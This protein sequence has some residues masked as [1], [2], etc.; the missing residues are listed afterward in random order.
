MIAETVGSNGD[1]VVD[2]QFRFVYD[3]NQI[4]LQFE[5]DGAGGFDGCR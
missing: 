5:K 4:V 2:H 3:G 1:G